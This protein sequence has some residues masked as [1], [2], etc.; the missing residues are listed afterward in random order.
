M[1]QVVIIPLTLTPS[2]ALVVI[3]PLTLT[4]SVAQ[5]VITP[6]TVTTSVAQVV[7]CVGV[8]ACMR[9]CVGVCVEN[10]EKH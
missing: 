9:E 8:S 5:V 4:P 6:W 3:I 2:V 7:M 10:D 1:A